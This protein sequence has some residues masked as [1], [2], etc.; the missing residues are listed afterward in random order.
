MKTVRIKITSSTWFNREGEEKW[1]LR[2]Q[3]SKKIKT[4]RFN[5][6]WKIYK[7]ARNDAQ[8]LIKCKKKKYFQ[9]K[10]AENKT[11]PKKLWQAPKSL[12]SPNKKNSPSNIRLK[13]KAGLLFES[14]WTEETFEKYHLL[15]EENF[16]LKLPNPPCNFG[17]EQ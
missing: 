15:L 14:L 13:N 7:E 4:R 17:K 1:S 5:I 2:D 3:L 12:W 8:G 9:K 11:N 10:L 6:D 16:S